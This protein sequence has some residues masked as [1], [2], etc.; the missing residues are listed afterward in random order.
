MTTPITLHSLETEY[1]TKKQIQDEN[2]RHGLARCDNEHKEKSLQK[3]RIYLQSASKRTVAVCTIQLDNDV[4]IPC[5]LPAGK[6]KH[7]L[8][9][10][11]SNFFN[12]LSPA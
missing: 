5:V 3:L 11:I 2:V 1:Y 8:I 4:P 9:I 6:S 10:H 7:D 12:T